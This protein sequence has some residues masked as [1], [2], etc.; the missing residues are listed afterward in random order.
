MGD[1]IAIAAYLGVT[2]FVFVCAMLWSKYRK[3]VVRRLHLKEYR[4][5]DS[6]HHH[7]LN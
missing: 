7:A 3:T 6:E 5:T 4:H 1:Y 2:L